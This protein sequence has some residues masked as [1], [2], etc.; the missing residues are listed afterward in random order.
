MRSAVYPERSRRGYTLI[1]LLVVISII[2]ILAVL[3]FV[4]FKNFAT[5]Q[6]T[7]KAQGQVQTLLRLAQSNATSGTLCGT[8]GGL[9]WSLI[10][11]ATNIGLACGLSNLVQKTYTLENAQVEIK[12]SGCSALRLPVTLSYSR[13]VGALTISPSDPCLANAT[14]IVFTISNTRNP[15][16]SPRPF[17]IS[18][19]G[20]IDVE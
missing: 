10:F 4:N 9:P 14:S 16:A 1:E 11:N 12:G 15:S 17:N 2:S 18:K 3:G 20:A 8:S 6:V 5:D 7:V 19:G 13:G